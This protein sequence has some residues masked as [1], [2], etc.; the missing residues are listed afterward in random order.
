M[1]NNQGMGF[2]LQ[3][4]SGVPATLWALFVG[5]LILLGVVHVTFSGSVMA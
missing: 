2:S 4:S 1:Q 3:A 5:I